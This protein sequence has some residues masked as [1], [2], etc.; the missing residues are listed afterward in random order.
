HFLRPARVRVVEVQ[1]ALAVEPV[2]DDGALADDAAFVPR[3]V[4]TGRVLGGGHAEEKGGGALPGILPVGA[5]GI[6]QRLVLVLPGAVI[7]AAV[8]AFGDLPLEA[9][10]KVVR[11]G[12]GLPGDVP[13]FL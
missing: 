6:V 7:H 3:T 8:A 2:L 1:D 10:L 9:Q 13:A 5:V 11:H 12:R 4:G